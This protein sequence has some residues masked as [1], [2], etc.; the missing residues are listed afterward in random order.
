M[1][2]MEDQ[3]LESIGLIFEELVV[4]QHGFEETNPKIAEQLDKITGD[5]EN[6]MYNMKGVEQ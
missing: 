3:I 4:I 1:K 5:L 2:R 6:L